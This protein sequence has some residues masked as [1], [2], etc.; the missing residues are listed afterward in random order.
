LNGAAWAKAPGLMGIQRERHEGEEHGKHTEKPLT[1][2]SSS[3][4]HR[5]FAPRQGAETA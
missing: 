2:C 3:V 1:P 4:P 5:L